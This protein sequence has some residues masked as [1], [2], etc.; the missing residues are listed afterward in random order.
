MA[1]RLVTVAPLGAHYR[2]LS[3]L[4]PTSQALSIIATFLSTNIDDFVVL[5]FLLAH[6]RGRRA[7]RKVF[8]GQFAGFACVL[9]VSWFAALGVLSVSR[10]WVGF[11]G[12]APLGLGIFLLYRQRARRN[13]ESSS[14]DERQ[15]KHGITVKSALALT[16]SVSTENLIVYTAYFASVGATAAIGVC[17]AYL[18][19]LAALFWVALRVSRSSGFRRTLSRYAPPLTPLLY[20]VIGLSML[21]EVVRRP[22]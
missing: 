22:P 3:M 17:A 6:H 9:I 4:R 11:L 18:A 2:S 21:A 15:R 7:I 13:E 14:P 12:L 5:L 16:L 19:M 20:I 8:W 1:A 10:R